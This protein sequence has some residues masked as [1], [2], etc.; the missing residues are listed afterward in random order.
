MGGSMG[1]AMG[2]AMGGMGTTNSFPMAV[3][4]GVG[5]VTRLANIT[6]TTTTTTTTMTMTI[7]TLPR[8]FGTVTFAPAAPPAEETSLA[9]APSEWWT[10]ALTNLW[11]RDALPCCRIALSACP[12]THIRPWF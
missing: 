4:K 12:S 10:T 3:G 6:T 9:L 11:P 2:G 7:T 5:I 8:P 1:D